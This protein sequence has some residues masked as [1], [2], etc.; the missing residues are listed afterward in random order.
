MNIEAEPLSPPRT[1]LS[2]SEISYVIESFW[3]I[4][5]DDSELPLSVNPNYEV[6]ERTVKGNLDRYVGILFSAVRGKAEGDVLRSAQALF[7]LSQIFPGKEFDH[8][9]SLQMT[10]RATIEELFREALETHGVKDPDRLGFVDALKSL[11]KR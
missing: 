7:R 4:I 9:L 2:P 8:A 3:D 1:E 11:F 10:N 5:R 6:L